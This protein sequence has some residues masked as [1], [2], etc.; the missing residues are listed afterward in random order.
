M[1][2]LINEPN[3][4]KDIKEDRLYGL[5]SEIRRFMIRNVSKTGGHLASNLGVVELTIALHRVYDLPKDKIIWDVGHQSY[6]HKILT[7]RK[8]EFERLRKEG[9]ISGFPRREESDCDSF[10]TGH[11]S[12]SISA[13][14]GYVKAREITGQHYNVVSVIGDGALTGGMAYEALNNAAMLK[15]N[16]VI[17]LNDNEM[18][19]SKSIGGM[20]DYLS[21]IRTSNHYNDLK[22]D[23]SSAL[24]NIPVVGEKLVEKIKKTKNSLKQ[25]F[26]PGMLFEN[27][28]ITYLGPIDGH[29]IRQLIKNLRDAKRVPGPVIV[30]VITEKG[31]G[32]APAFNNPAKFHG[33]S[34]FDVKTGKTLKKHEMTYADVFSEAMCDLAGENKKLVAVTA[35]M[36]DGTGLMDFEKKYPDRIFDVGIAEGHAVTFAA[37]LALGGVVP[38]AAIYSSFLQRGFDQLLTDVCMQNVHAI[39]AVDR[40][41]FVGEDGKSHQGLFDLSYLSMLPNMTVMAPKNADE[42]KRMLKFAIELDGPV[43]IRYPRGRAFT[44]LE[45]IKEPVVLGK[46]EILQKG[47]RVAILAIGASVE[48]ALET[49]EKLKASGIEPTVVNMRFVKPLDEELICEL[50]HDHSLFATIEENVKNGGFGEKVL[51]AVNKN[52]LETDVYIA[53]VDDMFMSHG[54]VAQQRKRAGI[55]AETVVGKILELI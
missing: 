10:D 17:V 41:G 28:G 40:A 49:A 37:S 19:I 36:K 12:N 18:S 6:T 39:F 1:L 52:R 55:D 27:M 8:E 54:T 9:G 50:S 2:E 20:A 47:T 23:V 26:I 53:A 21:E 25:L 32:Y 46:G 5:A 13:G 14:V 31:K 22:D 34:P 30:H 33:V 29:N 11:S 35:S 42:L 43:A 4:I 16:F 48:T 45:D 44:G 24:K 7:G 3:D 51:D 15:S 38:V